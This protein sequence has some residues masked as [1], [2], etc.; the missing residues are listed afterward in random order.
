MITLHY[1]RRQGGG[2]QRPPRDDPPVVPQ[3]HLGTVRHKAG[4]RRGRLRR[5]HRHAVPL[6]GGLV[7]VPSHELMSHTLSIVFVLRIHPGNIHLP[8]PQFACYFYQVHFKQ[9][10]G[11]EGMVRHL[12]ANACLTPLVSLHGMAVTT[13]EGIGSTK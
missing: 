7:I 13:V 11:E 4:L 5:L 2:R 10:S 12:S 3:E 1:S 9:H 8:Y 6:Q